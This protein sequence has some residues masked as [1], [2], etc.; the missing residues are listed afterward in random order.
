MFPYVHQADARRR[1][2]RAHHA[3]DQAR[4][5]GRFVFTDS[6]PANVGR[7][8]GFPGQSPGTT[9]TGF[10]QI[11]HQNLTADWRFGREGEPDEFR[12]ALGVVAGGR[13]GGEDAPVRRGFGVPRSGE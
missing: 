5:S 8:R 4:A 7:H 3:G 9:R 12:P 2:R 6:A 11:G 13:E 10:D 1:V